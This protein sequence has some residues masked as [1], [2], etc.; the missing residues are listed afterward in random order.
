MAKELDTFQ[1][2]QKKIAIATLKMNDM[3]ASIM[4]GM[5]KAEARNFLKS[6]GYN[7]NQI[8]RLEEQS[9]LKESDIIYEIRYAL[10]SEDNLFR[11]TPI[12][13]RD[14][15]AKLTPVDDRDNE[16]GDSF[17]V[18]ISDLFEFYT[19]INH[20]GKDISLPGETQKSWNKGLFM[21]REQT[22]EQSMKETV[23]ELADKY[24]DY[25]EDKGIK[26]DQAI[27]IFSALENQDKEGATFEEFKTAIDKQAEKQKMSKKKTMRESIETLQGGFSFAT[28][29]EYAVEEMADEH[30]IVVDW[31]ILNDD[32][33]KIEFNLIKLLKREFEWVQDEGHGSYGDLVGSIEVDANKIP[34]IMY[35]NMQDD[36]T[37]LGKSDSLHISYYNEKIDAYSKELLRGTS[38]MAYLLLQMAHLGIM[39]DNPNELYLDKLN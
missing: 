20:K 39:I 30:G 16:T 27:A 25:A 26:G 6:I 11:V 8:A 36:S 10:D 32:A 13:K 28:S 12:D 7:E 5:T 33:Q 38:D 4:G 2:H 3:G 23:S 9:M 19:L 35:K 34:K 24:L 1:K 22:E 31:N 15:L 18:P 17:K 14:A 21:K 37:M 29:D